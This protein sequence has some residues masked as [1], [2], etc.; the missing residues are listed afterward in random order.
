MSGGRVAPPPGVDLSELTAARGFAAAAVVLYH[1]D[2][3]SRDAIGTLIP[4][5]AL[6]R[7]AVD[8]F[9]VLSGFVLAHVYGAA[10]REGRYDHRDFL[11]RRIARIWPLH[12]VCLLGV[13]AIVGAGTFVGMAPPWTPTVAGFLE[14][15]A[16]L[17]AVG[18]IREN[19]WNQPSW[20]VGAEWTAYLCFPVYLAA[21]SA[22]RSPVAKLAAALALAAI[23]WAAVRAVFGLD[24]FNLTY[25]GAVRIVPSFFAGVALRQIMETGAG[26]TIAPAR[27][28]WMTAGVLLA[29]ALAVLAGAPSILVW[30]GLLAL[31]YLLALKGLAPRG[32]LLRSRPLVWGGEISYALYLAHAPVLMVTYGLGAKILGVSGPAGLIGLGALAAGL[33]VLAAAALHY[34]VERPAQ[35]FIVSRAGRPRKA[36]AA[37]A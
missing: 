30:P 1:V 32:G 31:V 6:A 24:L 29:M 5:D 2:A 23:L 12:L 25:W 21:V 34:V 13:A 36:A 7:L 16:L 10:W 11:A 27:L 35:R 8:F 15:A 26:T 9:F 33:S 3:Y 4:T 19:A 17:N 22:L 20:S 28:T 18:L 14:H 37:S